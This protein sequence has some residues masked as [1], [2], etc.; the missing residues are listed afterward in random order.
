VGGPNT[1]EM[2][3]ER[4]WKLLGEKKLADIGTYGG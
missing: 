4:V 1:A 3:Q 2:V